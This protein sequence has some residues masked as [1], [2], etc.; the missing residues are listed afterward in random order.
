MTTNETTE[1]LQQPPSSSSSGRSSSIIKL[2]KLHKS[3]VSQNNNNNTS[4]NSVDSNQPSSPKNQSPD[5][6]GTLSPLSKQKSLKNFLKDKI[7]KASQSFK[8]SLST[9]DLA[10]NDDQALIDDT[11][12]V[13]AFNEEDYPLPISPTSQSATSPRSTEGRGSFF[14]K[15]KTKFDPRNYMIIY[16][17]VMNNSEA[18]E[19]FRNYLKKV[20]CNEEP[21]IFF[22]ELTKFRKEYLKCK[23]Q[24]LQLKNQLDDSNCLEQTMK[25][26]K[27]VY[28]LAKQILGTFIK[29][30]SLMELNL[31]KSQNKIL[32]YWNSEIEP[33]MLQKI[34][35][36]VPKRKG[37]VTSNNGDYLSESPLNLPSS[38]V[39]KGS[40]MLV[41]EVS[42]VR[43]YPSLSEVKTITYNDLIRIFNMMDP[44]KVFEKAVFAVELDL[45]SDQFPRFA[46]S[47]ELFEFLEKQGENFTR[48]IAV[49]ISRGYNI[50]IRYKLKDFNKVQILE[51]DLLFSLT[52]AEDSPDWDSIKSSKVSNKTQLYNSKTT[53]SFGEQNE[54]MKLFK[55]SSLIPYP[56]EDVWK[57]FKDLQLTQKGAV[58]PTSVE[59]VHYSP[60][61][62]LVD[63]ENIFEK[64]SDPSQGKEIPLSL[65]FSKCLIDSKI[66]GVK[67]R[68][69]PNLQTT[70]FDEV[71][72]GYINFGHTCKY[73]GYSPP[74]DSVIFDGL[75]MYIIRR[76]NE[77]ATR[78]IHVIYV[79]YHLPSHISKL[80]STKLWKVRAAHLE[81]N[82]LNA[83]KEHTSN[84]RRPVPDSLSDILKYEQSVQ[85]NALKYSKHSW[86][87]EYLN[88]LNNP[89]QTLPIKEMQ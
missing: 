77:K 83:L 26:C 41:T 8:E 78:L 48:S 62:T 81:E 80:M 28:D 58:T 65:Q 19:V 53:Y 72:D 6:T 69:F 25:Y 82:M 87:Q 44:E 5:E 49:D 31:G 35:D 12:I 24:I 75:F 54:A 55:M 67:S 76:V 71:L 14:K 18:R 47:K 15:K 2:L 63:K 1:T 68:D 22:N 10:K 21:M 61:G 32:N 86:Y 42:P 89:I 34:R 56:L 64:A 13:L 9:R 74:K 40:A 37:S 88:I 27:H 79:D 23:H 66:P 36:V 30:A 57:V 38:P 51:R 73:P 60:C 70:V 59:L 39:I 7:S 52:M 29:S 4:I 33:Y 50:D 20:A 85:D 17:E 45:K 46:R 3:N 43:M 84:G 11:E 16:E